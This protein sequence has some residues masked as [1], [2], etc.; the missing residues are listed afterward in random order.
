[1]PPIGA[2]SLNAGSCWFIAESPRFHHI[3]Q[4]MVCSSSSGTQPRTWTCWPNSPFGTC[5]Q[6]G[7]RKLPKRHEVRPPGGAVTRIGRAPGGLGDVIFR[8]PDRDCVADRIVLDE[9]VGLDVAGMQ[10]AEMRGVDVA[11]QRLQI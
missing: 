1:M 6:N 10:E 11:L 7:N 5:V 8:R 9:V 2:P 3:T 4:Y